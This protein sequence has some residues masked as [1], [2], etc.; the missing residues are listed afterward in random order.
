MTI[1][2]PPTP[3]RKELTQALKWYRDR[4]PLYTNVKTTHHGFYGWCIMGTV[5]MER[6]YLGQ[7]MEEVVLP[8]RKFRFGEGE[9]EP[10]DCLE[11]DRSTCE[12]H[13]EAS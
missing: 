9:P 12:I 5:N 11:E 1:Q 3:D 2:F 13:G 4:H 6:T 10:S 7:V 8:Y